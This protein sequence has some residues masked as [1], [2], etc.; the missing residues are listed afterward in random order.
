MDYGRIIVVGFPVFA[1]CASFG[2]IIRADGRPKVS[3]VGLLLG[4]AANFILDPLFI[5]VFHW[6]VKGA[7]AATV[8]GQ[9]INAVFSSFA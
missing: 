4:A 6:G 1:I 8:I 7:A 9:I 3:M 2:S 5:F